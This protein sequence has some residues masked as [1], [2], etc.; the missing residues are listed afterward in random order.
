MI[1]ILWKQSM[2]QLFLQKMTF[3]SEKNI[4]EDVGRANSLLS[5]QFHLSRLLIFLNGNK[6]T[7]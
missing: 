6:Q 5:E 2:F 7:Y 3:L 1:C 4:E